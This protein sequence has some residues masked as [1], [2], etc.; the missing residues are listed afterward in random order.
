MN[1][2]LSPCCSSFN[3]CCNKYITIFCNKIVNYIFELN[4][5]KR[6]ILRYAYRTNVNILNVIKIAISNIPLILTNFK[7]LSTDLLSIS[8]I[9]LEISYA[10]ILHQVITQNKVTEQELA[11]SRLWRTEDFLILTGTVLEF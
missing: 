7:S 1:N 5:I 8:S 6:R 2:L 10:A 3:K 9:A 11:T 4:W